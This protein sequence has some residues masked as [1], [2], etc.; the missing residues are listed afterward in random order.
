ML[1]L[2]RILQHCIITLLL[3][4][5]IAIEIPIVIVG[6]T[7]T[8][9]PGD[10]IIVLG[11]KVIN[12]SP[13]TMLRLRLDK[14]VKLH[15]LGY[16]K[17]VIVSGG[18]GSDEQASEASIMEQYL[19]AHGI[20]SENIILEDQSFNTYQNLVNSRQI[21]YE[22]HFHTA[23]IVSNSSHMR[24]SLTIAKLLGLEASGA[25]APMVDNTAFSTRQYLREGAA[26]VSLLLTK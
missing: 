3:L 11:A 22:H 8:P 20:P 9:Q 7:S 5:I 14:A 6:Q 10:V 17:K 13:S 24:R 26:M 4:F 2:L 23:I 12:D 25:P 15:Q 16:A 18:Q 21:M 1:N 19:V